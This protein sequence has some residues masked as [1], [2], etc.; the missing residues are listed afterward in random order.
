ME[1]VIIQNEKDRML[2]EKISL[3]HTMLNNEKIISLSNFLAGLNHH[4]RNALVPIKTFLDL[5]PEKL[6][7]ENVDI[8]NLK[9]SKYW[10]ELY[11]TAQSYVDKIN[12]LIQHLDLVLK[13]TELNIDKK[14]NL[15]VIANNVISDLSQEFHVNKIKIER[16]IE[17]GL[18]TVA[19]DSDELAKLFTL[20]LKD[21]LINLPENS[22][23]HISL[24]K[25]DHQYNGVDTVVIAINDDGPGIPSDSLGSVFD[26]LFI[27]N[28]DGPGIPS[29][30]LGSVFD[31]LFI[32]NED[33]QEF[34]V[35][36]VNVFVIVHN[37]G[38]R[39][40][41]AKNEPKGV[42]FQIFLP[43]DPIQAL[44]KKNEEKMIQDLAFKK[45]SEL[46]D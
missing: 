30:S 24:A 8:G 19:G 42:V 31:P 39:V 23:L 21:E 6:Q 22:H 35:N 32:R 9:N 36:L 28:E 33:S 25:C 12:T 46:N 45:I 2:H 43:V 29:D 13:P 27:R 15:A 4:I 40:E 10:V 26:P 18:P 5:T 34:G 1:F 14:I 7:A 41:V 3:L 38:G 16:T 44:S 20:L 11:A 37:H 17:E